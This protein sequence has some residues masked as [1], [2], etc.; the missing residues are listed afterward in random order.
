VNDKSKFDGTEPSA[1]ICSIGLIKFL[2]NKAIDIF[3]P[4]LG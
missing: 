4:D 1:T 2:P 3:S